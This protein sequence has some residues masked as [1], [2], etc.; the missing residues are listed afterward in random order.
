MQ[1]AELGGVGKGMVH[2]PLRN[3]VGVVS[4][5]DGDEHPLN[6]ASSSSDNQDRPGA[7]YEHTMGHTPQDNLG[8]TASSAHTDDD[9]VG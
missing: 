1:H 7:V 4:I 3:S 2:K 5:L 8:K 9:Q 6:L